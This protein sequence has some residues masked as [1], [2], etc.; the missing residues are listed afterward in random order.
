MGKKTVGEAE[1]FV[2]TEEEEG[3]ISEVM[4][5]GVEACEK[6]QNEGGV[7]A[8]ERSQSEEEAVARGTRT[9]E[10]AVEVEE[11]MKTVE[12]V[13]A[14]GKWR[15]EEVGEAAQLLPRCCRWRWRSRASLF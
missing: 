12:G 9:A 14:E 2:R 10:G 1:A 11:G 15:W 13:G 5:E 6:G 4:G 8:F 7:L 3:G